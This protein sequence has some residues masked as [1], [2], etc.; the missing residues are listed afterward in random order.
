MLGMSDR[1]LVM[2]EGDLMGTLDRSEATQERVMQLASGL[3]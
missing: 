3:A 2:H 1:V